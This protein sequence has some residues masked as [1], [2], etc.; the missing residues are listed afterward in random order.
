ML[1]GHW[2]HSDWS[3]LGIDPTQAVQ[4]DDC[5][6][7][8]E[9]ALQ[10]MQL[11]SFTPDRFPAGHASQAEPASLTAR[12]FPQ[13][14]THA[15][16]APF[17]T[18]LTP[19]SLH[20][21]AASKAA[22]RVS[23]SAVAPLNIMCCACA[24][25]CCAVLCCKGTHLRHPKFYHR[26]KLGTLSLQLQLVLPRTFPGNNCGK[27]LAPQWRTSPHHNLRKN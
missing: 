13:D 7:A 18:L 22:R 12:P 1:D 17:G 3:T 6:T 20:S 2:E 5:A 25:L 9:L 27:P 15:V 24:V 26:H 8:A 11:S 4:D 16:C 14:N 21:G 23:C 19:H 10:S